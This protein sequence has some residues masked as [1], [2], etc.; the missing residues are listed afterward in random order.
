MKR[1]KRDSSEKTCSSRDRDVCNGHHNHLWNFLDG[2]CYITNK[3]WLKI[4]GLWTH[5]EISNY[6][7]I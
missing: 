4:S 7:E 3:L 1:E 6:S 5:S 2:S